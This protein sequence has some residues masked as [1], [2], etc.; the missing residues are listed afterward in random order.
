M[1]IAPIGSTRAAAAA[2]AFS[3]M[4]RVTS[5]ESLAGLVFG[6]QQMLV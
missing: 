3:M 1:E 2:F 6:M 5:A 4:N